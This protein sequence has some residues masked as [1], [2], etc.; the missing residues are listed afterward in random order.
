MWKLNKQTKDGLKTEDR[1]SG[2]WGWGGREGRLAR[3]EMI[4]A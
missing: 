2:I 3:V 1:F 4:K